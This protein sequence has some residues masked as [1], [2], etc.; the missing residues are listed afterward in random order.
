MKLV[1]AETSS[2]AQSLARSLPPGFKA[3]S[4][5]AWTGPAGAR[6]SRLVKSLHDAAAGAEGIWL[7]FDTGPKGESLCRQ[8]HRELAQTN[9]R[10]YR[11]RTADSSPQDLAAAF[12]RP[13]LYHPHPEDDGDSAPEQNEPKVAWRP[14]PSRKTPQRAATGMKCP[15][16][17]EGL[18]V[19]RQ[20]KAGKPFFGCSRFPRCRFASWNRPVPG[21]CPE[22]GG[23][24]LVEKRLSKGVVRQ[25]PN[26]ECRHKVA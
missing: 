11:V 22:C 2:K 4:V 17:S 19:E 20:T 15:N 23:S 25:C 8:L 14:A 16:C 12:S 21:P 6:K 10:L 24:Y 13:E 9:P 5:S 7:A 3:I 1:L 18:I 26:R